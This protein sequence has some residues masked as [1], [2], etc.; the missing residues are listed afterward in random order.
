MTTVVWAW[1]GHP[2]IYEGKKYNLLQLSKQGLNPVPL[3]KWFKGQAGPTKA[4]DMGS[5]LI[6]NAEL[7]EDFAY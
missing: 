4:L 2:V 7:S 1:N 6:A 3:P 5:V